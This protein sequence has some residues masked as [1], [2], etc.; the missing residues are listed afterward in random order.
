M[1]KKEGSPAAFKKITLRKCNFFHAGGF[2]SFLYRALSQCLNNGGIY[3]A[4]KIS[5]NFPLM[6]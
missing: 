2:N 1:I 4:S 6:A 3:E 5:S